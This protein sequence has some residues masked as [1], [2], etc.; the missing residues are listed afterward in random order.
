MFKASNA[1][2]ITTFAAERRSSTGGSPRLCAP[3]NDAEWAYALV[4]LLQKL[5][6]K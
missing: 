4:Q 6:A 5:W 2:K 3:T 1:E